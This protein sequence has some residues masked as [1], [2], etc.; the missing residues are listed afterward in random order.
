MKTNEIIARAICARGEFNQVICS[1]CS[2]PCQGKMYINS[3]D[4]VLEALPAAGLVIVPREVS[5]EAM[6]AGLSKWGWNADDPDAEVAQIWKAM[7]A[8]TE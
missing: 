5:D 8:E 1:S 6:E 7:I 2:T 3:V 4:R